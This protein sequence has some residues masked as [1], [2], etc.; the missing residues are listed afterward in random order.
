MSATH[1]SP[2][3]GT[4]VGINNLVMLTISIQ[5]CNSPVFH[6]CLVPQIIGRIASSERLTYC[7]VLD[8][9]FWRR[10]NLDDALRQQLSELPGTK[11]LS[12]LS[13]RASSLADI[14]VLLSHAMSAQT[15][16]FTSTACQAFR[17]CERCCHPL[18]IDLP[19]TL[20][21]TN[22]LR[23]WCSLVYAKACCQAHQQTG[24]QS[25]S[26]AASWQP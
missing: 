19:G 18:N 23:V 15:F 1:R 7:S 21:T 12:D 16:P 14:R 2:I 13:D 25:P 24:R 26:G 6:F 22:C 10:L 5:Y 8:P 11:N 17:I 20:N 9:L 3:G 4:L